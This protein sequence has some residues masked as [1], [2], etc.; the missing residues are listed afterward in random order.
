MAKGYTREQVADFAGVTRPQLNHF[1]TSGLVR[2]EVGDVRKKI[3]TEE[4]AL[5]MFVAAC[6]RAGFAPSALEEPISWL[7]EQIHSQEGNGFR[8]NVQMACRDGYI[9]G[10]NIGP[11]ELF[12]MLAI[13]DGESWYCGWSNDTRVDGSFEKY[14]AWLTINFGKTLYDANFDGFEDLE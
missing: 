8:H 13:T 11:K 10:V 9:E 3:S 6:I 12:V 4:A 5:A 14:E 1:M 2:A 7:R